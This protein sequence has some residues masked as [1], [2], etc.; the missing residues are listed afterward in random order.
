MDVTIEL[1]LIYMRNFEEIYNGGEV[2]CF[3]LIK[4]CRRPLYKNRFSQ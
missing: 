1:T 3:L 4:L 2:E